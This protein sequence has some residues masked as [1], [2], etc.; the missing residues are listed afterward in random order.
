MVVEGEPAEWLKK[1]KKR[2]LVTNY[3]DAV[4]QSLRA[5][6][7]KITEHDLKLSQLNNLRQIEVQF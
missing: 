5:F 4:L 6:N 2:G 7:E 1:W 3:T